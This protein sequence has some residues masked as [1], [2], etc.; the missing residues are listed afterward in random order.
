MSPSSP[1]GSYA[2]EQVTVHCFPLIR[3]VTEVAQTLIQLR[4]WHEV[5]LPG[6]LPGWVLNDIFR[7]NVRVCLLEG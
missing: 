6:G 4:I 7:K 1:N 2:Y 3:E 5:Q